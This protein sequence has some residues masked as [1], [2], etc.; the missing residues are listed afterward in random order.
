MR[1]D[2]PHGLGWQP[3]LPDWR[4]KTLEGAL[5]KRAAFR[6]RPPVKATRTSKAPADPDR[7]KHTFDGWGTCAGKVEELAGGGDALAAARERK[8]EE[9]GT[10]ASRLQTARRRAFPTDKGR[11]SL[12][13]E[14]PPDNLL[15]HVDLRPFMSPIEDQGGIG[16]CT[17]QAVTGLVE[18]LQI[19]THGS[20]VDASRLFLYKATRNLLQ[21]TGDTGAYIRETIKAVRLFGM[22]PEDYWIY[23]EADFDAEPPAF[24]YA[25]AANYKALRFY[26]LANL[27]DIKQSLS[28][29]YPVAFGFTCFESLFTEEVQRTGIIPFPTSREKVKGGHAVLAVGYRDE[30]GSGSEDGPPA[31]HVIIRNSWG[32]WGEQGY[33]FLPYSFFEPREVRIGGRTKRLAPLSDDYWTM[34]Q[35]ALPDLSEASAAPFAMGGGNP[36]F[37]RSSGGNRPFE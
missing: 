10:F 27:E 3:D 37:R 20:Y 17:A 25:F 34:T 11:P 22:C 24:C 23:R 14:A 21:W 6:D 9:A 33:G 15:P 32:D 28:Q 13:L 8:D 1:T 31:G 19:A 35:M 29:G 16:S 36:V 5:A 7:P 26:R 2:I 18:Y 30:D 12:L 4:D